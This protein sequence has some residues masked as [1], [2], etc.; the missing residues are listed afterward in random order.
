MHIGETDA[1]AP[2]R[3]EGGA[4]ADEP[5]AGACS[6]KVAPA[7]A[8]RRDDR[9]GVDSAR[10]HERSTGL[11]AGRFGPGCGRSVGDGRRRAQH[12]LVDEGGQRAKVSVPPRRQSGADAPDA[13]RA[14]SFQRALRGA[15]WRRRSA[16][17]QR[18][19]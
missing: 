15:A 16:A 17:R 5:R 4:N 1:D 19:P 3:L 6:S 8:T 7:P 14:T 13:P 9:M 18:R 11:D 12:C 2:L 10:R